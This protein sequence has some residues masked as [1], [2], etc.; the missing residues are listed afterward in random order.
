MS[1]LSDTREEAGNVM[2]AMW[3]ASPLGQ[4]EN[5]INERDNKRSDNNPHLRTTEDGQR[6]LSSHGEFLGNEENISIQTADG[7]ISI[8]EA[9]TNFT[10]ERD[11]YFQKDLVKSLNCY[12]GQIPEEWGIDSVEE[13]ADVPFPDP[14]LVRGARLRCTYGTHTRKLNLP[15][16]HGVYITKGGEL[17]TNHAEGRHPMIHEKDC[18]PGEGSE[19]FN[20][21]SF[22]VCQAPNPPAGARTVRLEL[23]DE[24]G[25]GTGQNVRGP[26]CMPQIASFWMN[27]HK[28]TRIYDNDGSKGPRSGR[29][30]LP[31]S[32]GSVPRDIRNI[33]TESYAAVTLASVLPCVCGGMIFPIDSGQNNE[34]IEHQPRAYEDEIIIRNAMAG[35]V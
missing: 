24:Y 15:I 21:S 34:Q 30:I 9:V 19:G 31:P 23:Q 16:C 7:S 3:N 13:L 18:K 35:E 2:S 1:S 27:T 29:G 5:R 22:G 14:Y 11:K 10:N 6:F 17:A 20:I 4:I 25:E 33:G 32:E 12:N 28:K 26:A 8:D